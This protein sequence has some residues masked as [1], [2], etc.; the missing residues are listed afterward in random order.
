MKVGLLRKESEGHSL[1]MWS[2]GC[3][4]SEAYSAIPVP[5]D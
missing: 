1:L 3:R 2:G 5:V 4:N